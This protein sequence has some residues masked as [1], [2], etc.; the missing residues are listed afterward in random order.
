MIDIPLIHIFLTDRWQKNTFWLSLPTNKKWMMYIGSFFIFWYWK[1]WA[2]GGIRNIVCVNI[3]LRTWIWIQHDHNKRWFLHMTI[4]YLL[5]LKSHKYLVSKTNFM[6]S[7][8]NVLPYLSIH[9]Y[10]SHLIVNNG[11]SLDYRT[12]QIPP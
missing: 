10:M 5:W 6:H 9:R 3:F 4:S 12:K 8:S 1:S 2:K 7:I 11:Q